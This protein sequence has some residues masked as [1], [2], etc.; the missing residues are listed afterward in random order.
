MENI[1]Y[2]RYGR[3]FYNPEYHKKN[4]LKWSEEDIK[5]LIDWYDTIG[6]E[7]MSFALERTSKTVQNKV[8]ELRKK[9]IMRKPIKQTYSR[10]LINEAV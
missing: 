3:M 8:V 6:P 10:R 5:Y 7:E 4:G 1:E 2:D 9:G